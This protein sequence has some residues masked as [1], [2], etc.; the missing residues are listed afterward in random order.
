MHVKIFTGNNPPG[1]EQTLE[2]WLT[3]NNPDV[4]FV[5]QSE[6]MVATGGNIE[7]WVT[8]TVFFV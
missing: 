5:N 4:K 1:V 8:I 3:Q 6:S 2:Q 7:R